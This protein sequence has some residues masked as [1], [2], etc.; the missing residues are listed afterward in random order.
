[1]PEGGQAV[2]RPPFHVKVRA[3]DD[4]AQEMRVR[5]C[6][7]EMERSAGGSF[8]SSVMITVKIHPGGGPPPQ[9]PGTS[10]AAPWKCHGGRESSCSRGPIAHLVAASVECKECRHGGFWCRHS[11]DARTNQHGP[12]GVIKRESQTDLC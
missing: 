8:S 10:S 1:M 2:G 11:R 7:V 5:A 3:L 4:W 12:L 9:S 6:S